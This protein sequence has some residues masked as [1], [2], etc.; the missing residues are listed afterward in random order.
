L[1]VH[2]EVVIT[3][4]VEFATQVTQVPGPGLQVEHNGSVQGWQ[5]LFVSR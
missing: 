4:K 3:T 5:T 1:H 2:T